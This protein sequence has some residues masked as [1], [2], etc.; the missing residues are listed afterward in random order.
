MEVPMS[1]SK[2]TR[3]ELENPA[4]NPRTVADE[5]VHGETLVGKIASSEVSRGL[6]QFAENDSR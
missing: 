1:R 4:A 2:K 5:D 6:R 3:G